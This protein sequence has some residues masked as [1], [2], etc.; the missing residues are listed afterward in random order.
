VGKVRAVVLENT[1]IGESAKNAMQSG[2]LD[3]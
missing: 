3:T 1:V 2:W